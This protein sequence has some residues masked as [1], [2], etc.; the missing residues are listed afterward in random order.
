MLISNTESLACTKQCAFPCVQ[1]KLEQ[2]VDPAT[3][4]IVADYGRLVQVTSAD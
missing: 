1:V 2:H 3:P 4:V